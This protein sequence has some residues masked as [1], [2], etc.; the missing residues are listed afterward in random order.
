VIR[1]F[2]LNLRSLRLLWCTPAAAVVL[3]LLVGPRIGQ[4][5]ST[6][7][8]A[9]SAAATAVLIWVPVQLFLSFMAVKQTA[10]SRY[11]MLP[12]PTSLQSRVRRTASV[13]AVP[14]VWG[15]AG[16]LSFWAGTNVL[17]H[18][19]GVSTYPCIALNGWALT[20]VAVAVGTLLA[21]HGRPAWAAALAAGLLWFGL[22]IWGYLPPTPVSILLEPYD[23]LFMVGAL[24]NLARLAIGVVWALV[25]LAACVLW[26]SR[27]IRGPL[28]VGAVLFVA[29]GVTWAGT[30]TPMV[31]PRAGHLPM[32]CAPHAGVEVCLW[33][34]HE[35]ARDRFDHGVDVAKKVVGAF[36]LPAA[37][38]EGDISRPPPSRIPEPARSAVVTGTSARPE[39][40]EV[41]ASLVAPT[42]TWPARCATRLD[43]PETSVTALINIVISSRTSPRDGHRLSWPDVGEW[44]TDLRADVTACRRPRVP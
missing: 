26:V 39:L 32:R 8:V 33:S 21:V 36:H 7:M 19:F 5:T 41:V 13:I 14:I 1:S 6:S 38:R 9:S 29:V 37:L 40:G 15:S 31:L 27:A 3:L 34:D 30:I 20:L 42:F 44:L 2:W 25:V 18:G 4:D 10:L 23:P 11:D 43:D 17:A 28:V 22:A 12:T 24:P 35:N 16:W